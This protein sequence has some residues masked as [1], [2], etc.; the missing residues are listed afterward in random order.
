MLPF[1]AVPIVALTPLPAQ[2]AIAEDEMLGIAGVEA[3]VVSVA[4]LQKLEAMLVAF[5]SKLPDVAC[6]RKMT[7]SAV[8]APSG[9]CHPSTAVENVWPDAAFAWSSVWML[10]SKL[11][12]SVEDRSLQPDSGSEMISLS[13]VGLP[14]AIAGAALSSRPV[15]VPSSATATTAA[16]SRCLGPRVLCVPS[17]AAMTPP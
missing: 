13:R 3:G 2:V 8:E 11:L 16:T 14:A 7:S 15:D 12:V 6:T 1:I 10:L 17:S 4:P 5:V 9:D